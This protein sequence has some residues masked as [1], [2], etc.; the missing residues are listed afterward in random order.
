VTVQQL[1]D[2]LSKQDPAQ[3]VHVRNG[4]GDMDLITVAY[5]SSAPT[6]NFRHRT[7][8]CL[9]TPASKEDLTKYD[10]CIGELRFDKAY[11]S[12]K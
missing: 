8:I 2:I 10:T 7:V 4:A 6:G 11:E 5:I 12:P 9:D 1:M 3:D